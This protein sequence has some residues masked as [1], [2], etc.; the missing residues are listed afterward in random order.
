MPLPVATI[1][2]QAP[3]PLRFADGYAKA[4]QLRRLGV[5]VA[6]LVPTAVPL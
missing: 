5:T 1:R 6:E 4:V 3:V 2:T